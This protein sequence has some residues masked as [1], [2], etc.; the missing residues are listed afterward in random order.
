MT[1]YFYKRTRGYIFFKRQCK[2]LTISE[3]VEKLSLGVL[4]FQS[5][6]HVNIECIKMAFV[7]YK[8]TNPG[9]SWTAVVWSKLVDLDD[10]FCP[11]FIPRSGIHVE[12]N[13]YI[14][15]KTTA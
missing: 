11:I 8:C 10:N 15:V 2:N 3:L 14:N 6:S 13:I 4:R 12:K 9:K 5:A 1:G 7:T